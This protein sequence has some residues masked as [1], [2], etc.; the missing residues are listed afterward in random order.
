MLFCVQVCEAR[1]NE[2][3]EHLIE[4]NRGEYESILAR[5]MQPPPQKVC[6]SS[7]FVE[8]IIK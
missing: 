6:S 1:V 3:T 8:H 2:G 4:Q 5:A 7:V